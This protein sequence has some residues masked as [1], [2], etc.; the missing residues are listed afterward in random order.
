M[1]IL[2]LPTWYPNEK[3]LASGIFIREHAKAV[4]LYNEVVVLYGE[5]YSWKLKRMWEVLSDK[6]EDAIRTI[7]IKNKK[8]P[9]PK[10]SYFI[11]LHSIWKVF[12]GLL[13]EGWRP[14]II[15]AHVYSAGVPAVIIG[16]KYRIPVIITEHW[17]YF[18]RHV[19]NKKNILLARFAMNRANIILPVSNDLKE[20]I[21]SYRINNK[22]EIVPNTVNTKIFYPLFQQKKG[23][24]K[25][26]LTVVLLSPKKGIPYLIHALVQIKQRR[27]DFVLDIVGD[28]SNRREYEELVEELGL[29]EMVKFHGLKTKEEVANFMRNCDFFVLPSLFETFGVV[30]IEAMACGKPVIAS[31]I[32]GP[33][34][35][36]NKEVG[37][38]VPPKD[39]DA[40]ATTIDYMLDHYQDYSVG[41]IV[42]YVRERYGYKTV[43][44]MLTNIYKEVAK[45]K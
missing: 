25:K 17:T 5:D 7:R 20:A 6:N 41:K 1:K 11:Y 35:I 18:P 45:E 39:I 10:I 2:F 26:I 21:K 33:N 15:H 38:L 34:E 4:S 24:T 22:F 14:D 43:G 44:K 30:L 3:N 36:V 27:Q 9:I 16:K 8:L 12:K 13:K 32:G 19:L 37:L 42:Q 23:K 31:D 40:L 29:S 28:G